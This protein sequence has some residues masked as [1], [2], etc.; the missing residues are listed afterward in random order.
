MTAWEITNNFF[1]STLKLFSRP[2]NIAMIDDSVDFV[3]LVNMALPSHWDMALYTKTQLMSDFLNQQ[4][5]TARHDASLFNQAV[6]DGFN[7]DNLIL[8][9]IQYWYKNPQR[10][11]QTEIAVVDY[12]MPKMTGLQ[13]LDSLS[14]WHGLNIL[15]TGV[16]NELKAVEAF[17]Q[18]LIQQYIPKH[19]DDVV[20]TLMRALEM[21][22]VNVFAQYEHVCSMRLSAEQKMIL[23]KVEV[24]I[25]LKRF[26]KT[27]W[28]E[29]IVLSKPFGILGLS[30]QGQLS[31]LQLER[32]CDMQDLTLIAQTEPWDEASLA[33]INSGEM[34]SN[35]MLRQSMANKIP[36]DM[37]PLLAIGD[38][39][40]VAA[41]FEFEA[42]VNLRVTNGY[43]D[44]STLHRNRSVRT[45]V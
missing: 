5:L 17:N 3:E 42:P 20:A 34:L 27:H 33:Q 35:S 31:W 14:N 16:A 36:L 24:Q 30:E 32:A 25:F 4:T 21:L 28:S 6:E 12:A 38:S 15:L 11:G 23:R 2:Y 19:G 40:W 39:G 1:M 9:I 18:G 26:A 7:N 8:K 43:R 44:W 45:T 10:W 13:L 37:A 41:H 29:Y 22:E